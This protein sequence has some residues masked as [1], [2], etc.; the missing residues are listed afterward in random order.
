[1]SQPRSGLLD[2]P[3]QILQLRQPLFWPSSDFKQ[4]TL[5]EL[6]VVRQAESTAHRPTFSDRPSKFP[7][8]ADY[9][10]WDENRSLPPSHP[11][12]SRSPPKRTRSP[13]RNRCRSY[14]HDVHDY[15]DVRNR[16]CCP[17]IAPHVPGRLPLEASE[18]CKS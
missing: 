15:N 7:T 16:F 14:D 17:Q 1:M 8:F 9:D 6:A 18:F 2:L 5:R 12:T 3:V 4:P 10:A 13:S 11:A